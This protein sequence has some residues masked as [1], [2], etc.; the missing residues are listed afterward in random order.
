MDRLE[1][2]KEGSSHANLNKERV[3]QGYK[4]EGTPQ[5]KALDNVLKGKNIEGV[6]KLTKTLEMTGGKYGLNELDKGRTGSGGH[7]MRYDE[8]AKKYVRK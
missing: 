8:K 7:N 4:K 3:R 2:K 5:S 6:R 1:G